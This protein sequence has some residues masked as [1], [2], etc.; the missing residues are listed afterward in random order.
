MRQGAFQI[1]HVWFLQHRIRSGLSR[2]GT[3]SLRTDRHEVCQVTTEEMK[4]GNEGNYNI[5]HGDWLFSIWD[6]SSPCWLF[7]TAAIIWNKND[8]FETRP[9]LYV[10]C[11]MFVGGTSAHYGRFLH[12]FTGFLPFLSILLEKAVSSTASIRILSL[13]VFLKWLTISCAANKRP[14]C[15]NAMTGVKFRP[16]LEN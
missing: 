11:M 2:K 12:N 14:C 4:C 6:T 1:S 8:T 13:L 16:S 5:V 7:W 10:H 15:E 9:P 3:V